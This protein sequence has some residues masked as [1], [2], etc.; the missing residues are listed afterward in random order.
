M[1]VKSLSLVQ[2][3]EPQPT[4]LLRPWDL[5]GK[6]TEVGCHCLLHNGHEFEQTQGDGEGQ[7]SSRAAVHEV[8][9]SWTQLTNNIN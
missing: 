9:K 5:P 4:T 7:E 8:K 3:Q 1:K 2:L 6:S